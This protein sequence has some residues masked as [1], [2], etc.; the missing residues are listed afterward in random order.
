M[1]TR[2]QSMTTDIVTRHRIREWLLL[3]LVGLMALV[4]NLPETVLATLNIQRGVVMA[5]LGLVV[6]MALFLYVRFFFFLLYTLLAVGANLPEKWA[7][8]LHISQG[9]LLLTLI[10]MV[11]I[12]LLNYAIKLVPTGLE[13]KAKKQN[14]EAIKAL[15]N[16]IERGN[17]TYVRSVLS[18]DF[19]VNLAGENGITPLMRAAQRGDL[20][21]VDLL[22]HHGA[23]PSLGGMGG[24]SAQLAA[25]AGHSDLAARLDRLVQER[26]SRV[27]ASSSPAAPAIS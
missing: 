10:A 4:A 8:A 26:R 14:P 17:P 7:D 11:C 16:A 21:I 20:K 2:E 23:D 25:N 19:D 12:S 18:M 22:L 13:P 1:T 15:L 3:S 5:V 24:T 6:I 9:P 27:P